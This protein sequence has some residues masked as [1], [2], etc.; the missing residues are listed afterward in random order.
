MYSSEARKIQ[1]VIE[2]NTN[3][4]VEVRK[5]IKQ[6]EKSVPNKKT[7][8]RSVFYMFNNTDEFIQKYG[9]I[10]YDNYV[11]NTSNPA[12][13]GLFI[14]VMAKCKDLKKQNEEWLLQN[15]EIQDLVSEKKRLLAEISQSKKELKVVEKLIDQDEPEVEIN[16]EFPVSK[17]V[18]LVVED[19]QSLPECDTCCA[20]TSNAPSLK[21][22][23]CAHKILCFEC[24]TKL[25]GAGKTP[26][27]RCPVCRIE[28]KRF[29]VAPGFLA[30]FTL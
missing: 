5:K 29:V 26:S 16:P 7:D 18:K 8:V 12:Q 17:R 21:S 22:M 27:I 6:A 28:A 30:Y 2:S 20:C 25:S 1:Q 15:E 11:N 23:E 24:L 10:S 19:F 13:D 14:A 3:E 4:L 9:L